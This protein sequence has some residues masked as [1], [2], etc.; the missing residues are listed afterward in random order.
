MGRPTKLT[1]KTQERIVQALRLGNYL[2]VAV[3]Y[4]GIEE[5]TFYNWMER[6][7]KE[8]E[9]IY[10]EFFEA[11]RGAE[12]EAEVRMVARWQQIITQNPMNHYAVKDFLE[13]R[14]KARWGREQTVT[15]D[16]K[17]EVNSVSEIKSLSDEDLLKII[18]A[19]KGEDN[20]AE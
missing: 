19:R 4:A 16:G 9:G 11:V 10:F 6:G 15:V 20:S 1:P 7:K 2:C 3:E 18:N 8:Q 13:K 5:Q 14:Y 12:L 17:L